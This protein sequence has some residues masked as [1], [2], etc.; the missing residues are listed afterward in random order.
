M[1][2]GGRVAPITTLAASALNV[3]YPHIGDA[4]SYSA[5]AQEVH[6][7]TA[8]VNRLLWKPINLVSDSGAGRRDRPRH[9]RFMAERMHAPVRSHPADHAPIVSAAPGL[10]VD[11]IREAIG[12][13]ISS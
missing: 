1:L 13:A 3:H 12:E 8:P 5:S 9:A 2:R 4:G 7:S 6:A 11:I 10:V